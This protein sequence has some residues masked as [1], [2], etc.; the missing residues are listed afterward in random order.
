MFP[1]CPTC[2]LQLPLPP[3]PPSLL[4][5]HE[6]PLR[7]RFQSLT[8]NVL[9]HERNLADRHRWEGSTILLPVPGSRYPSNCK[10]CSRV[11]TAFLKTKVPLFKISHLLDVFSHGLSGG[12]LPQTDHRGEGP[13][14]KMPQQAIKVQPP[15]QPPKHKGILLCGA[16]SLFCLLP[17][18]MYRGES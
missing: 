11:T 17:G 5:P 8:L 12:H 10:A 18:N 4:A 16:A 13:G 2:T 3:P 9:C 6:S 1:V 15:L 14:P 7:S